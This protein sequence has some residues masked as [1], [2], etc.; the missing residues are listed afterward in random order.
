MAALHHIIS[1][2]TSQHRHKSQPSSANPAQTGLP[3]WRPDAT[4][5]DNGRTEQQLE[6]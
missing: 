5:M 2:T 1:D 3:C 4:V 6:N